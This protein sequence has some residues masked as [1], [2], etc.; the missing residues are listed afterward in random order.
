MTNSELL[1]LLREAR[2]TMRDFA[3]NWDCDTDAHKYRT[4]CRVCAAKEAQRRIDAALAERQDSA[5]DAVESNDSVLWDVT[6]ATCNGLRLVCEEWKGRWAWC[7]EGVT[8][9]AGECDTLD[10]AKSA[11]IAAA[12]GLK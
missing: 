5:T 6:G 2:E 11:A 1:D 4:T 7:I 9:L 12:R 8:H 3:E 10:E